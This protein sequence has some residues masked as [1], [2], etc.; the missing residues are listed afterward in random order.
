M[1]TSVVDEMYR[2]AGPLV[3]AARQQGG[4]GREFTA[5]RSAYYIQATNAHERRSMDRATGICIFLS[6][7][8]L[9]ST[10]GAIFSLVTVINTTK[11]PVAPESTASPESIAAL[12][13][14]TQDSACFLR[15][16]N[17]SLALT[18]F[19]HAR[20]VPQHAGPLRSARALAMVHVAI[21]DA[22]ALTSGSF[23]PLL[24]SAIH[25]NNAANAGGAIT[26]AAHCVLVRLFSAQA[27]LINAE[28]Q[29][30]LAS[31]AAGEA[32]ITSGLVVGL[33]A[34]RAALARGATDGAA[35]AE[36][37][38]GAYESTTP[39]LWRRDPIAGHAIAL[40]ARWAQRVLPWALPNASVFRP[41][42]PP[43][44]T[45]AE[46][47]MEYAEVLALGGDGNATA[48]VRDAWRT[49]IGR[50][51]AYDGTANICAPARLYFQ[52]AHV[53]AANEHLS[54]V[55]LARFFGKL[56]VIFADAGLAAWDAKYH[57]NRERP[58]TGIRV[59]A[60]ADGNA[61]TLVDPNW[62]PLGAPATNDLG[63][64]DFTPPFPAYP[65]GHAVFGGA[66]AE[67]LREQT[68]AHDDYALTLV[69]DEYD[70]VAR[71]ANGA[72]RPRVVRQFS[73]FAE[74][75]EENGQSRMYL[76]IHWASDKTSGVAL[77]H[78]VARYV[79]ARVY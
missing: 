7:V 54:S 29:T 9:T 48:T 14:E 17:F 47:A 10:L 56:S 61:H 74:I 78:E 35:H 57:Y 37:A 45:S 33:A 21:A 42:P 52:I 15:W 69:S 76:G 27:A 28:R 36:P 22:V 44:L 63:G 25:A 73:S 77:G 41:A 40:G 20:T 62:T 71:D 32:A 50:F 70:G 51:W 2:P 31:I 49:F 1:C 13:A 75:E 59:S 34:C 43:A 23:S 12:F 79:S 66:L 53:V 19:D 38:V 26:A 64:V 6:L 4:G 39:G 65:S 72:V 11:E 68:G 8:A 16:S 24:A 60:A 18:A 46:Y 58:I 5:R 67:F 55:Q 30:A 3:G